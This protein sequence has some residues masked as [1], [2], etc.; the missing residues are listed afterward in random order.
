MVARR[1]AVFTLIMTMATTVAAAAEDAIKPGKW[2]YSTT[3]PGVHKLP[4]GMPPLPGMDVRVGPEGL[5]STVT[6]CLT[7]ADPWPMHDSSSKDCKVEKKEINGG[8]ASL[9]V[10]CTTPKVTV[11]EDW[12]VHYHG[13]TMDGQFTLHGTIPDRPPVEQHASLKGHYLGPCTAQ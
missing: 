6:I 12:I 3:V 7:T 8:T 10:T 9:S 11:Q 4:E 2:E 5:T 1:A 13:E